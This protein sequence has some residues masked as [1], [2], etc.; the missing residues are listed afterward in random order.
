MSVELK[1]ANDKETLLKSMHSEQT[2]FHIEEDWDEVKKTAAD[3]PSYTFDETVSDQK[4]IEAKLNRNLVALRGSISFAPQR[5]F[6][7]FQGTTFFEVDN[8]DSPEYFRVIVSWAS[9]A[10]ING[11]THGVE[12]IPPECAVVKES[13][14]DDIDHG[15][16]HVHGEA[17]VKMATGDVNLELDDVFTSLGLHIVC[18]HKGKVFRPSKVVAGAT[19]AISATDKGAKIKPQV[20]DDRDVTKAKLPKATRKAAAKMLQDLEKMP[21]DFHRFESEHITKI[22]KEGC[23]EKNKEKMHELFSKQHKTLASLG[24]T[25]ATLQMSSTYIDCGAPYL[26]SDIDLTN[27]YDVLELAV[28]AHFMME[29]DPNTVVDTSSWDKWDKSIEITNVDVSYE[30]HECTEKVDKCNV[31]QDDSAF[32]TFTDYDN[33]LGCHGFYECVDGKPM[34]CL[35]SN[36]LNDKCRT[37]RFSLV[38]S[39]RSKQCDDNTKAVKAKTC[40]TTTT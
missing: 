30:S 21:H 40:S 23:T 25:I 16:I 17:I 33:D 10:R 9:M 29:F 38:K 19:D 26:K 24:G 6:D 15:E 35:D 37:T 14:A 32:D 5:F 20:A 39:K 3:D 11:F 2:C 13:S 1:D 36:I 28:W 31:K 18:T 34:Q 7:E 12:E 27:T 8:D 22:H 4:Y